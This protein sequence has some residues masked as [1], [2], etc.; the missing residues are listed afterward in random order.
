MEYSEKVLNI[1]DSILKLKIELDA[2]S[3][4]IKNNEVI[5]I[6]EKNNTPTIIEYK[7][8]R[9]IKEPQYTADQRK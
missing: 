8:D 9:Y 6:K 3:N 7:G 2:A 4:Y 5:V 1:I